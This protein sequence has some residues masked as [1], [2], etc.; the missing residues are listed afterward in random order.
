MDEVGI[1]SHK[2]DPEV[3]NT[4]SSFPELLG[5]PADHELKSLGVPSV[6]TKSFSTITSFNPIKKFPE[7]ILLVKKE[8]S[9]IE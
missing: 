4:A 8:F 1:S 9:A 6:Q 3:I 7:L 2:P 5:S